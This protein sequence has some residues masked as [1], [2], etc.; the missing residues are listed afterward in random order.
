MFQLQ[1]CGIEAA[2]TKCGP[3]RNGST[4]KVGCPRK[5]GRLLAYTLG[6]LKGIPNP[7]R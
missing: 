1:T 6:H 5:I 3:T 4:E 2:G 7:A